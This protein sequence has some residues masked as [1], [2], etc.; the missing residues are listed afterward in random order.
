MIFKKNLQIFVF[1][2]DVL[3]IEDIQKGIKNTIMKVVVS[4]N[5]F[6]CIELKTKIQNIFLEYVTTR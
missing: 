5:Q 2:Q 3:N 6:T 1:H 4:L